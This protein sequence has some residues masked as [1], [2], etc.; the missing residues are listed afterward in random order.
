MNNQLFEGKLI[1][2][3][4]P[5]A[6]RDAEIESQWTHNAEFMR[7][8]YA[9]PMHPISPNVIKKK[10]QSANQDAPHAPNEIHYAIRTQAD[11]RLVGF[12]RM[13]HIDWSNSGARLILAIPDAQERG[14]GYGT[15]AMQMILHYAFRELNLYR[16]STNVLECNE[17]ALAFLHKHGFVDEVRRRQAV[18]RDGK[19][20]D[21]LMLG[22]LR[23]EW[24]AK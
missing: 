18:Q 21:W 22:L 16:V 4:P 7:L 17:S 14:K 8:V 5:N 9:E 1:R 23:D 3:A 6:E 24:S 2:L 19:Y 12:V 11:D 13:M 10:Y 15:E 20:W